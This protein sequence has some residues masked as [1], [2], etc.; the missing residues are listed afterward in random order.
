MDYMLSCPIII[1][2]VSESD[3]FY[4]LVLL[5]KIHPFFE[6]AFVLRTHHL[7]LLALTILIIFP[8]SFLFFSTLPLINV[9]FCAHLIR[10]TSHQPNIIIFLSSYSIYH[11]S[12]RKNISFSPEKFIYVLL[13]QI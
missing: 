12:A 3:L 6:K 5:Y 9:D 4:C 2:N 8:F 11:I 10:N 1:E 7:I 13:C